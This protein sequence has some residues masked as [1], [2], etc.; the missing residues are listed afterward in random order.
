MKQPDKLD[1]LDKPDTNIPIATR[2]R[3]IDISGISRET[4]AKLA[5]YRNL[6]GLTNAQILDKLLTEALPVLLRDREQR[7]L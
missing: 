4:Q 1:K 2:P 3:R 6:T 7:L 5:M